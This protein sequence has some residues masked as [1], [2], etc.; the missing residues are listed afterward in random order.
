MRPAG[1]LLGMDC[2]NLR[3]TSVVAILPTGPIGQIP[4][5]GDDAFKAQVAGVAQQG[6]LGWRMDVSAP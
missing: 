1:E 4:P 6:Q 5:L 3:T 2:W